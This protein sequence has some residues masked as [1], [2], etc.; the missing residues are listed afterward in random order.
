MSLYEHRPHPH[1]IRRRAQGPVKTA[2]QHATG[3]ALARFNTRLGLAITA[4]VGTMVCAYVFLA[5]ALV[6]LPSAISSGSLTILVAWLSSNCIQLVLLP[7]II[8]GQNA[9]A[10]AADKRAEQTYLD[11]EAIL[12]EVMKLQE[13]L[14]A[15]DKMLR[16]SGNSPGGTVAR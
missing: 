8:V 6:S 3:T 15:Q 4:A 10:A 7:V 1:I 2:D 9:Q 11:A 16:P 13:H 12:A 14:D 5:I